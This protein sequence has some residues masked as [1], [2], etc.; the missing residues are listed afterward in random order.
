MLKTITVL[1]YIKIS[2]FFQQTV[3]PTAS[4]P[5]ENTH[6]NID[7]WMSVM[8]GVVHQ[9]FSPISN[10]ESTNLINEYL[11]RSSF[12]TGKLRKNIIWTNKKFLFQLL[13]LRKIRWKNVTQKL[14]KPSDEFINWFLFHDKL[15]VQEQHRQGCH[16]MFPK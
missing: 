5:L 3:L 12:S 13:K 16:N 15:P 8:L 2:F 4:L 6:D 11:L 10:S 9:I 14:V 7:G 1:F